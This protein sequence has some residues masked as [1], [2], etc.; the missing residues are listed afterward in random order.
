M[1]Y[2]ALL[3]AILILIPLYF[4]VIGTPPAPVP[5]LREHTSP[6]GGKI[7]LRCPLPEGATRIE[8]SRARNVNISTSATRSSNTQI[9]E[10]V[11]N[12]AHCIL[13]V[14]GTCG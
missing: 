10:Y 7:N 12:V 14:V 9:L 13:E 6:V 1:C 11:N 5:I 4:S 8:W 3:P 2:L